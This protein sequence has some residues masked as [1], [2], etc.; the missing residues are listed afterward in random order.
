MFIISFA[1]QVTVRY[2]SGYTRVR[3]FEEPGMEVKAA[4]GLVQGGERGKRQLALA[5]YKDDAG[6]YWS[7]VYINVDLYV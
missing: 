2:G 6:R 4:K 3:Y 5:V 1:K 7:T